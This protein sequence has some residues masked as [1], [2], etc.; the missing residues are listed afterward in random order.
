[1]STVEVSFRLKGASKARQYFAHGR[2]PTLHLYPSGGP[3]RVATVIPLTVEHFSEWS[4]VRV[5]PARALCFDLYVDVRNDSS[6]WCKMHAAS[7]TLEMAGE[8]SAPLTNINS[9][10]SF[11]TVECR[12]E[13]KGPALIGAPLPTSNAAAL[14]AREMELFDGMRPS[15]EFIR[16]VNAPFFKGR[17]GVVS[18]QKKRV[19]LF[20]RLTRTLR[21]DARSCVLCGGA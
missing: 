18:A 14:A 4:T 7:A 16:R 1:M 8:S 13:Q 17:C 6:R 11:G 2:V 9:K 10:L 20:S 15:R 12:T 19:G 21:V 3:D 5:A